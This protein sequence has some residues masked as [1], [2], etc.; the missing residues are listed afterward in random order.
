MRVNYAFMVIGITVM[1][2]QLYLELGEFSNSLLWLRVEETAVGAAFAMI[3]ATTVLPLRTRRVLCVALRHYVQAIEAVLDHASGY[4]LGE[5]EEIERVLRSAGRDVDATYQAL[6]ATAQPLRRNIAGRLDEEIGW[7]ML[8]AS[9]CRHYSH[10]LVADVEASGVFD[11]ETRTDI[12]H[13][14]RTL[15]ES[16]DVIASAA[17][18]SRDLVYTRSSAL[19]DRA[20][21]RLDEGSASVGAGRLAVRDLMLIDGGMARMAEIMGL[22][23]TDFDTV[24]VAVRGNS[25]DGAKSRLLGKEQEW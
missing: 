24:G 7:V 10:D 9:S 6:I 14:S 4:L 12:A 20:E 11:G 19:F 25:D 23:I 8:L 18:S 16:L 2:S 15:H 17:T 21:R 3:V 22:S 1:V 5:D 13:A